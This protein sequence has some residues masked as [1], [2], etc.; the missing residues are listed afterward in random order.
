MTGGT[1]S[2]N[3]A[4]NNVNN[5]NFNLSANLGLG[6]ATLSNGGSLNFNGGLVSGATG[7]LV[8]MADGMIVGTGAIQCSF[9][10]SG[11]VLAVGNGALNISK[12]FNN[13]GLI[14]LTAFNSK[15]TGGAITNNGGIRRARRVRQ[16]RD[17][18]RQHRALWGRHS[19]YHWLIDQFDG[20]ADQRE[21]RQRTCSSRRDLPATPESSI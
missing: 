19:R 16:R 2:L 4:G 12:P 15:L 1:L 13:S 6:A 21:R 3:P 18:H 20:R 7:S 8:N 14:E 9:T 10:N 5:G 17:E 11:G